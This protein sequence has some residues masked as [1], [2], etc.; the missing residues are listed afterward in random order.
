MSRAR[1]AWLIPPLL[2]LLMMLGPFSVD[3]PFPAFSAIQHE[4]GVGTAATQQLVSFYLLP[5]GVM[6]IF[7]GPLSDAVG[8]KPVIIGGIAVYA[9]ASLGCAFAPSMTA[10]LGFRILQGMSAGGGVVLSRT[11]VADLYRGPEAQRLMSRVMMIFALAPAVAPIVGGWAVAWADWRVIFWGLAAL[12]L[13]LIGLVWWVL[14]ETLP[15]SGRT[16]L[17]LGPLV[18]NLGTVARDVEFEKV[19][20][21]GAFA[22]AGFFFYIGAAAIVVVDILHLGETDFWV[23]F[24]PLIFGMM[25]GSYVSGRSAGRI[26]GT[27]L[28]T[29]AL[30]LAMVT[31][32]VNIVLAQTSLPWVLIGPTVL[33]FT[34]Q[35]GFPTVQL[36]L[37]EMFPA[38]RG[39][40]T[41]VMT[42]ISLTLNALTAGLLTP[43]VA[44]SMTSLAV[45][46]AVMVAFALAM[47]TW[48]LR[49][50]TPAES[51]A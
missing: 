44:A 3:T 4:F 20:L 41:S 48:H 10:L 29:W 2:A 39:A 14:P 36:R 16:P 6:S 21:T 25:A 15:V 5:F 11:L 7:H 27:R 45:S 30:R 26:P 28:V 1:L 47:W 18:R 17:R 33:G 43:L 34:V 24:V 8:R 13:L 19:A 51:V 23:L 42:L 12:A 37:L 9:L 40:A 50:T 22:F 38:T 31:S 32:L 49:S 35:T 46:A